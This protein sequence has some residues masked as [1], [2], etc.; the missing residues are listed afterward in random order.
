MYLFKYICTK[1]Y[2]YYQNYVQEEIREIEK[3]SSLLATAIDRTIKSIEEY[4]QEVGIETK[5]EINQETSKS[6]LTSTKTITEHKIISEI[7]QNGDVSSEERLELDAANFTSEKEHTEIE[8]QPEE[9]GS[10]TNI[11]DVNENLSKLKTDIKIN[12]H[13]DIPPQVPSTKTDDH[14]TD[15]ENEEPTEEIE[16]KPKEVKELEIKEVVETKSYGIAEVNNEAPDKP[17]K[18][19]IT[20]TNEEKLNND[21][22]TSDTL[23]VEVEILPIKV[24]ETQFSSIEEIAKT[25]ENIIENNVSFCQSEG[26]QN[27]VANNGNK[28]ENVE[29]GKEE[30]KIDYLQ[31]VK[32][33]KFDPEAIKSLRSTSVPILQVHFFVMTIFF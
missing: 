15:T 8:K 23:K 13:I 19:D 11:I 25:K 20:N 3:E 33:V 10:L 5:E 7:I 31:Y 21:T 18:V 1:I 6:E 27:E 26:K 14:K 24:E 29:I 4:K 16:I 12:M 32:P 2:S 28:V 17:E 9:N 30:E 22:N